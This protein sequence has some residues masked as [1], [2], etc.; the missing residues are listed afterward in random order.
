MF[1]AICAKSGQK[2]RLKWIFVEGVEHGGE[3]AL[4]RVGQQDDNLLAFVLWAL[5]D[6]DGS[7]EGST[8]RDTYQQAF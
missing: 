6:L 3:V 5:G 8:G 1:E 7:E 4:T 2:P